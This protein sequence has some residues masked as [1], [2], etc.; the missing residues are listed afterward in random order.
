MRPRHLAP[1]LPLL[2]LAAP[3]WSVASPPGFSLEAAFPAA[4]GGP[5]RLTAVTSW[6]LVGDLDAE[7][8]LG[9][10]SAERP[11]GRAADALTAAL[12][13]R[14]EP[15]LGRWRPRLGA[16]AGILVPAR[17]GAP[18]RVSGISLGVE[19]LARRSL[20]V[21]V[22]ARWRWIQA[23]APGAEAIVGLGYSP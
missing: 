3:A 21:S 5:T 6:W 4:P 10:G 8:R 9:L 11:G 22:A 15:D 2:L 13:L 14:W 1:A 17:G 7:A 19:L 12:G 20:S 23:A 16:D 18:A